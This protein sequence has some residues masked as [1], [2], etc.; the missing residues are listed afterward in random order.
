MRNVVTPWTDARI[1]DLAKW[2]DEGFSC[3]QIAAKLGNATRNAVI[4]KVHRMGLSGR[5][6]GTLPTLAIRR[7]RAAQP[8]EPPV[9]KR[10]F[11]VRQIEALRCVEIIPR[12]IVL[13]DL[14][15][16][17]C[18]YPYGEGPFTFCGNATTASYCDAHAVLCTGLGTTSERYASKVSEKQ[19][20]AFA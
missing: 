5:G 7:V 16:G 8:K 19:I 14:E 17:D 9:R 15:P 11:T 1:A 13:A 10:Q 12:H 6:A 18:R 20:G 3:S 2:W 4:G